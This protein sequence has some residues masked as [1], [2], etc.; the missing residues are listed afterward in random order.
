M[1]QDFW[2]QKAFAVVHTCSLITTYRDKIAGAFEFDIAGFPAVNG[3]ANTLLSSP[4]M[5]VI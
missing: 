4:S 1:R 5:G 3:K 2:D